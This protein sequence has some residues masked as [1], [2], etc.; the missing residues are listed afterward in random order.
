VESI[1]FF[2]VIVF[3]GT[4]KLHASAGSDISEKKEIRTSKIQQILI[5]EESTERSE[6]SSHIRTLQF[7]MMPFINSSSYKNDQRY[8]ITNEFHSNLRN[9]K[10]RLDSNADALELIATDVLE[11][12]DQYQANPKKLDIV[13]NN[14]AY[15]S[16]INL[17][18]KHV[19]HK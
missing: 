5:K 9:Q 14:S 2:W 12:L 8:P 13:V 18:N 6:L 3:L 7:C 1:R 10:K 4:I 11:N 19:E 15:N 17:C 16:L